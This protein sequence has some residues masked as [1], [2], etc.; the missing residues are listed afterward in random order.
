[1]KPKEANKLI[2]LTVIVNSSSVYLKFTIPIH[3]K[4]KE[5]ANLVAEHLSKPPSLLT[6]R[7]RRLQSQHPLPVRLH[8]R[9]ARRN[10]NTQPMLHYQGQGDHLR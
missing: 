3:T 2:H 1:M 9:Q 8:H 4:I 7:T 5:L 10:Q 6:P